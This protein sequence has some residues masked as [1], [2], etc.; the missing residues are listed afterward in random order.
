MVYQQ[1]VVCN[2]RLPT[3]NLVIESII[4]LRGLFLYGEGSG[5][6]NEDA[7]EVEISFYR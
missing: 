1:W 7:C 6:S 5:S 3:N 2:H 4:L